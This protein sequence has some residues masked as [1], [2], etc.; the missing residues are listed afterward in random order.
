[1]SFTYYGQLVVFMD[2]QRSRKTRNGK[3]MKNQVV[4]NKTKIHILLKKTS[5][6]N[7]IRKIIQ[8]RSA[9]KENDTLP[10]S[11]DRVR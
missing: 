2:L 4:N 9:L 6:I 3:Q 5:F 11:R 8:N 1:M 7:S 10:S